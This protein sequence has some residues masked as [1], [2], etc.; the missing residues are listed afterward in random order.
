M[1]SVT[2]TCKYHFL[3]FVTIIQVKVIS[4]HQVK[5]VKQ[6]KNRDLVLRYM[7]LVRFSQRTPK[8]TL[9]HFFKR[10]NRSKNK[11]QKIT[12]MSR[13]DVKNACF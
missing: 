6:K 8:M 7:F 10:Q 13:N 3:C 4:G 12:V 1:D 2:D 5:K 11:I 9:K